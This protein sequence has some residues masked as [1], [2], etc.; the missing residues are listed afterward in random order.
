MSA[1]GASGAAL[2]CTVMRFRARGAVRD[3]GKVLGLSE[4]VTGALAAQ[5]WGWSEE[6]VA[7]EHAA[8]LG[9][10][11]ADRR[12]RASRSTSPASSSASPASSAPIPAASC[13][14]AIG[15]TSWFPSPLPR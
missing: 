2:C 13:S 10:N 1:T 6:G 7:E 11:L 9:L 14:H 4:D 8:E 15:S 12:L 3:V 5:V